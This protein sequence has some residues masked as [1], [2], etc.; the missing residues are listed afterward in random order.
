MVRAGDVRV[1]GRF[2]GY[3]VSWRYRTTNCSKCKDVIIEIAP[4]NPQGERLV[5][6]WRMVYPIGASR[7]PV[8]AEVPTEMAQDSKP[9]EIKKLYSTLYIRL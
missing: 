4:A 9:D 3:E 1:S 7:G 5:S 6:E 2:R 8:S